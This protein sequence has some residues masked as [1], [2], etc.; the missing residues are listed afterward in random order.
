MPAI[1]FDGMICLLGWRD[2]HVHGDPSGL[3]FLGA[4]I[5]LFLKNCD[6]EFRHHFVKG[7]VV[8]GKEKE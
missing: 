1:I 4:G 2:Y 6:C 8:S 7:P 5:A 3:L